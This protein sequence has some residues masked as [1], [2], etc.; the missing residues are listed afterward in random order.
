MLLQMIVALLPVLVFQL[1]F[2]HSKSKRLISVV[3][4]FL[5]GGAVIL[6]IAAG[7][8]LYGF[9]LDLRYIPLL[10][11]SLYGGV[12]VFLVTSGVYLIYQACF[13]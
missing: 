3:Y 9:N 1:W 5:C 12:F 13:S 8:K 2:D 4:S 10:M 7:S 6:T 11:G